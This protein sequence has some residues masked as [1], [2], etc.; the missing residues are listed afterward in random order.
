MNDIDVVILEGLG[1][2]DRVLL[3]P[4]ADRDRLE[5]VRLDGASAPPATAGG[6]T[7]VGAQPLPAPG[8]PPKRG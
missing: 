3:A 2:E 6:D 8:S 4:P 7:A 1:D 5:F